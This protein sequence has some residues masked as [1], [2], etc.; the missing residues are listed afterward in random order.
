MRF[1]VERLGTSQKRACELAGL[2]RST[3]YYT[4]KKRETIVRMDDVHAEVLRVAEEKPSFGYRRTTAM[5][6]RRLRVRVNE[7]KVRRIMRAEHLTLEPCVQPPRPRIPKQRG[8]QLTAEPDVAYQ[9]DM[10]YIDCGDDLWAYLQSVV[11][12]CTGEWLAY[13]FS[14]RSGAKEANETLDKLV[15]TRFPQTCH[16]PGTKLRVDNGPAYRA[17][18][19]HEHARRLGFDIEHI[20]VKTPE[21]NGVIESLHAGLDRDYLRHQA[22]DSFAEANEYIAWAFEDF[23]TNMPRKRL[24]WLTPK[25]Y[26]QARKANAN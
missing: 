16:A 21:D 2:P 3:Y 6:R 8:K 26:Y 13:V 19:F 1:L 24:G 5:V 18:A 4:P 22:F 17:E 7:K 10:K 20:Q 14:F 25:E 12:C 9:M 15:A 23:N 11:D